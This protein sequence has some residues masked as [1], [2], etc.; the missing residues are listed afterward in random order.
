MELIVKSQ[1]ILA[2]AVCVAFFSAGESTFAGKF[3]RVLNIGD[4]A[5][6]FA[7]LVGTDGKLHSSEDFKQ[8]DVLVVA[9][10]CNHCPI[11]QM[12]EKRFIQ[13][14]KDYDKKGVKLIAVGC[15]QLPS[16]NL[17]AMKSHAKERGFNFPYVFD[18]D[19]KTGKA[20]G[21]TSTPHVFVIGKTRKIE[22]MGAFD[23]DENPNKVEEAYVRDA[24]D[25]LLAGKKP[26][27]TESRQRGCPIRYSVSVD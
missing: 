8:A 17:D 14:V 19:Q 3:N 18:G 22:Y 9:F 10:I 4:A 21:A 1:S 12:Y 6:K 20:F 26:D 27:V 25:S 2:I 13:L 23:D 15:S 11:A 5:P 7:K 16:D 24:I